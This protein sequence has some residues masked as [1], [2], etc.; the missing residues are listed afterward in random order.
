MMPNREL[1]LSLK[2]RASLD[3]CLRRIEAQGNPFLTVGRPL[4]RIKRRW[5]AF[6]MQPTHYAYPLYTSEI[7]AHRVAEWP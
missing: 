6:P 2:E 3:R 5:K 1:G 4:K 7:S